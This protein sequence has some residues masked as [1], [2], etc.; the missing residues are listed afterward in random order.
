[1]GSFLSNE[2]SIAYRV[3]PLLPR[4]FNFPCLAQITP[5]A[6]WG[7][8]SYRVCAHVLLLYEVVVVEPV[9][10]PSAFTELVRAICGCAIFFLT[11]W[12]FTV[13]VG[14]FAGCVRRCHMGAFDLKQQKQNTGACACNGQ[15]QLISRT[16]RK[17]SSIKLVFTCIGCLICGWMLQS[18]VS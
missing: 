10:F 1:M 2:L 12:C 4:G 11:C 8:L 16:N 14:L 9:C 5:L 18:W 3:S 13:P 7:R 6:T 17:N 15:K